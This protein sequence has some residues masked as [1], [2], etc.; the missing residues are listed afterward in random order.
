M[1]NLKNLAK[2]VSRCRS[3]GDLRGKGYPPRLRKQISSA[4]HQYGQTNVAKSTGIDRSVLR[5]WSLDE[6]YVG[7]PNRKYSKKKKELR[8]VVFHELPPQQEDLVLNGQDR[9]P[10]E[11]AFLRL[12]SP[13]G[14]T[15]TL[16]GNPGFEVTARI[17]K[18]F[19][20]GQ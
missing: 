15:I 17:I 12:T 20:E 18:A 3:Q 9:S 6:K 13:T 11:G 10:S 1:T 7:P 5:K 19:M 4:V 2:A 8:P 16:A 14:L